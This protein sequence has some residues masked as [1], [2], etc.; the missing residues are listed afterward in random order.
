MKE[1]LKMF[2]VWGLII[3]AVPSF[4]K[5]AA[6][7]YVDAM[8][9]ES[10]A[11][12]VSA[13]PQVFTGA[14][15]K[16]IV[17]DSAS[18]EKITVTVEEYAVNAV[19]GQIPHML[20]H[21]ALKAQ[22]CAARTYAVRRIVSGVD[23]LTGAHITDDESMYQIFPDEERLRAVYGDEY[24]SAYAAVKKAADETAGIII[25]CDGY[26][27]TAAFH[28]SSG[29]MTESSENVWGR[30]VPYLV[31]V[32]SEESVVNERRFT[33][34][35]LTA[36]LTA[37]YPEAEGFDSLT[38]EEVTESGTVLSVNVGDTV[39]SGSELARILTLDS[40]AFEITKA[41]GEYIFS[42]SGSGH[43][44][45]MSMAGADIMAQ[46]GSSCEEI[47]THYYTGVTLVPCSFTE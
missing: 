14:S 41:D 21:E 26:P 17:L 30:A 35:E 40:T 29:G 15:D 1:L 10:E 44:C 46:K 32:L 36:R 11:V 25:I 7:A 27:I 45:G 5:A 13:E 8:P 34:A 38:A 47:I 33:E 42:V 28:L 39:I 20:S 2:F 24:D 9:R 4:A 6:G 22:V 16:L 3:C 31:P 43:L 23:N 37:V 19:L 12:S 18:G